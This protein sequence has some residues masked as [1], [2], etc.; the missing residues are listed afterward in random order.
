MTLAGSIVTASARCFA[1][2]AAKP[3]ASHQRASLTKA[4]GS[5]PA[6]TRTASYNLRSAPAWSGTSGDAKR[7]KTT[8]KQVTCD[9][10]RPPELLGSLSCSQS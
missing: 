9:M 5:R 8:A 2:S 7:V 10:I 6:L 4:A 1:R 3:W